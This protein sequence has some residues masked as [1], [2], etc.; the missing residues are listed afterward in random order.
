MCDKLT[1]QTARKLSKIMGIANWKT[2]FYSY[3]ISKFLRG[4]NVDCGL[5]ACDAMW[6]ARGHNPADHSPALFRTSCLLTVV[7]LCPG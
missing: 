6:S 3:E 5:L 4:E 7:Y 1:H 2:P